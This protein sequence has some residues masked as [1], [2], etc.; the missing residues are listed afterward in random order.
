MC[1]DRSFAVAVFLQGLYTVSGTMTWVTDLD[2][3]VATLPPA[4]VID[5]VSCCEVALLIL[6]A[7][8]KTQNSK[9]R[10][11]SDED[12]VVADDFFLGAMVGNAVER[13]AR[14]AAGTRRV[15]HSM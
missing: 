1:R 6:P 4:F 7:M 12:D 9:E 8:E 5:S 15:V 13:K 14:G 3:V 11:L 2:T 10:S